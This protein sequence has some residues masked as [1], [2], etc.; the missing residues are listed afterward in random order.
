MIF[1]FYDKNYPIPES[2][3]EIGKF[4]SFSPKPGRTLTIVLDK[5]LLYENVY[6]FKGSSDKIGNSLN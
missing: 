6:N 1:K 4:S 2:F 3:K 5:N